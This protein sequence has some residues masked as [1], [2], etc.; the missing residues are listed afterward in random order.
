M[1]TTSKGYLCSRCGVEKIVNIYEVKLEQK[2]RA[3]PVYTI[4]MSTTSYPTFNQ[5]CPRC[6]SLEAFKVVLSTHGDH[7]GVK[8][9]RFVERYTC[10]EC[11][12]SWIKT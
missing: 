3:E 1:S 11:G 6:D 8:Q 7:A 10:L 12:H 4:D 2:S 5:E 9:D